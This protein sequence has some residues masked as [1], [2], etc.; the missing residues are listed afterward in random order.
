MC[1]C[2]C[3]YCVCGEYLH[4]K[5][6]YATVSGAERKEAGCCWCSPVLLCVVAHPF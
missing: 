5:H 2:V 4:R 6:L 3:V 1:V